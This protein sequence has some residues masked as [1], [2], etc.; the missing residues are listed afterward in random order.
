MLQEKDIAKIVDTYVE[1]REEAGYSHLATRK[2]IL[3]NQYNLNIPRYIE[4]IDEEIPQDVDAHVFG[5]IPQQNIADLKILQ[6]MVSD[7]LGQSLKQVRE[8]YV[9]LIKSV[10]DI[11]VDVLN[12]ARIIELSKKVEDKANVYIDKYWDTLRNVDDQTN[13]THLMEKM[14]I[15]IKEILSTFDYIDVYDGY[16]I[17]AEIWKKSLTHDTELIKLSDF[18]TVGRTREPNMV[19]KGT[20]NKKREEQDG[21]VGSIVPNEL[22]KKHLF[23]QEV[24]EIESKK[25]QIQKIETE[26]SELVDAAKIE[27]SDEANA[28][29]DTL[30]EAGEV[31]ESKAVKAELKAASKETVEYQLLKKSVN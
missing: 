26:L 14:L 8:G 4:S 6:S 15:E 22:I 13:L 27:D 29:G 18:Y 21:W 11:T 30:N 17:V 16:Q 28:L 10:D 24:E 5:G 20:G 2:E 1:R 31:F 12:D 7:I 23:S 19:T 3:E 25:T 9:G